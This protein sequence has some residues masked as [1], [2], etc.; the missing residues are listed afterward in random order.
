MTVEPDPRWTCD[1]MLGRLARYLRF[2]GYDVVYAR[3]QKDSNILRQA[4][5]EDRRVLTRDRSMAERSPRVWLLHAI[6]VEEQL[7]EVRARF[8]SLRSEVR[9][10]RCS[11]CNGLLRPADRSTPRPPKG[12]PERTWMSGEPVFLCPECGQAYWEGSHTDE[13]RRTLARVFAVN[14]PSPTASAAPSPTS[15]SPLP[16]P[17][18]ASREGRAPGDQNRGRE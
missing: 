4:Q 16:A 1:E 18:P 9:F 5:E 14:G 17:P 8:P 7:R 2:L 6:E 11:L 10:V 15:L 12:V 13:I 3:N